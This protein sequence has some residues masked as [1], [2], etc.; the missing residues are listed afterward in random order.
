DSTIL[1]TASIDGTVHF[2]NTDTLLSETG[3]DF[4]RLGNR[5]KLVMGAAFLDNDTACF[6]GRPARCAIFDIHTGKIK[7]ELELPNTEGQC[8]RIA[9][10]PDRRFLAV[11]ETHPTGPNLPGT[12]SPV[13][14]QL[15]VFDTKNDFR[16][17]QI[18]I[19]D[20]MVWGNL[21]FARDNRQLV[22]CTRGGLMV[23]DVEEQRIVRK[24]IVATDC[25]FFKTASF[26]PD[27]QWLI[28]P[29]TDGIIYRFDTK[30]FTEH[31]V[32]I[33]AHDTSCLDSEFSPDGSTL[34]IVGV[35]RQVKLFDGSSFAPI[36]EFE[37]QPQYSVNVHYSPDGRRILTAG[38][39][40]IAKLWHAQTGEQLAQFEMSAIGMYPSVDF[41]PDGNSIIGVSGDTIRIWN[42]TDRDNVQTLSVSDL[43][44]LS[45]QDITLYGP[46]RWEERRRKAKEQLTK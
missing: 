7:R 37:L 40:G 5:G 19:A 25:G 16:R 32:A 17:W 8:Y 11:T 9:V 45:C 39:D 13:P 46:A 22:I 41:S 43:A 31:S 23:I 44:E 4:S 30:T 42:A 18:E 10:S 6:S 3:D 35:D 36:K 2:W 27:G 14:G 29:G 24:G 12:D 21:E 1:A 38:P 15:V 26:S 34:A 33:D 20:G 28:A